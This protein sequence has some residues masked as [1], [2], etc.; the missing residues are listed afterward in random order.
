MAEYQTVRTY[1]SQGDFTNGVMEMAAEGWQV[2]SLHHERHP[3]RLIMLLTFGN[4]EILW[5][6]KIVV[7]F[8]KS[9][10]A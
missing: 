9:P 2:A 10:S 5:K 8:S 7:T 3:N 6:P 4:P 1:F